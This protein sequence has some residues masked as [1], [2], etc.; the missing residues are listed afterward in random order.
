[1]TMFERFTQ[2]ARAT[3]V[4]AQEEARRRCDDRVDVSRLLLAVADLRGARAAS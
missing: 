3:V 2:D 4:A 1:M